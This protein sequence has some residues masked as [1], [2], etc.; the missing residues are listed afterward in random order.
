MV[1]GRTRGKCQSEEVGLLNE[2]AEQMGL[3]RPG[4]ALPGF[5]SV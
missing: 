2:N 3:R 1:S 4:G 5:L